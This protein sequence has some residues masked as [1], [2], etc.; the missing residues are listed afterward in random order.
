MPPPLE[1]KIF[2]HLY[3]LLTFLT[4]TLIL[5]YFKA[6]P[7]RKFCGFYFREGDRHGEPHLLDM[8]PQKGLAS[9]LSKEL[10]RITS[11]P[12]PSLQADEIQCHFRN[13]DL[14]NNFSQ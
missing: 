10:I 3:P 1:E 9:A 4:L 13:F 12:A 7:F 14:Q 11:F 8:S 2:E 6:N 5:D